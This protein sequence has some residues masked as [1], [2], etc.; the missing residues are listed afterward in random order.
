MV[1]EEE[2][3]TIDL[4]CPV[5]FTAIDIRNDPPGAPADQDTYLIDT[6]PTGAWVGHAGEVAIY[7]VGPPAGWHFCVN[8]KGARWWVTDK[9][10]H[11]H[12]NEAGA[13]VTVVAGRTV[14]PII[15]PAALTG[16]TNDWNPTGLS[17]AQM[18]RVSSTAAVDITGMVAQEN[19]A[20]IYMV[21][22][23]TNNIKLK[24]NSGN[25]V[26]ANRFCLRADLTM[27]LDE[28]VV[29]IY[30]NVT[31]RWRVVGYLG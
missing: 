24:N 31:A 26:A 9:D 13:W 20:K 11:Y 27:E 15:S 17:S 14:S 30:D 21:N 16:N 2:T 23:G 1:H 25:S 22:I 8:A 12:R 6:A 10:T 4:T 18:I 5:S 3:T 7:D 19:G 29:L 28:G